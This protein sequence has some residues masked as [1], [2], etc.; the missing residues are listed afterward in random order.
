M[1]S[2]APNVLGWRI[3]NNFV[4]DMATGT[5]AACV[6]VVW[7]I[8]RRFISAKPLFAGNEGAFDLARGVLQDAQHAVWWLLL[9]A[10]VALVVTGAIRTL[11]WR[12][13]TSDKELATRRKLLIGKH[14]AFLVIYGLG[15]LWASSLLIR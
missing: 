12:R 9:G 10:L 2:D 8:S 5:W 1:A 3:V 6:L 11:Y 7:M 13:E 4:H 14:I 15:S